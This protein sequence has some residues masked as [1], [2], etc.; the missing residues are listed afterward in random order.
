MGEGHDYEILGEK[1]G[2]YIVR[3]REEPPHDPRT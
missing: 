2:Y 3:L 1:D